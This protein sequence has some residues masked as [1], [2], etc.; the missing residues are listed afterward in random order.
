[1]NKGSYLII[2]LVIVVPMIFTGCLKGEKTHSDLVGIVNVETLDSTT[3]VTYTF[4]NQSGKRETVLGG[5]SYKL[6]RDNKSVEEGNVPVKDYID[7]DPGEDY[8]DIK[9]FSNLQPGSYCIQVEWNK[10][11]V[12]NNFVLN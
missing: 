7:L 8:T 2:L 11:V 10:T 6:R 12:S 5:A 9:I 1:M 4:K 3:T